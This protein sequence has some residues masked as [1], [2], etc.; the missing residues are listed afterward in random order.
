VNTG[1][2][3]APLRIVDN[4]FAHCSPVPV[5]DVAC[6]RER[7]PVMADTIDEQ[8]FWFELDVR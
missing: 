3:P 1:T 5:A 6:S 8:P 4:A 7:N 2:E